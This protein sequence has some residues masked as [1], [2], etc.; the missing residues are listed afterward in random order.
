LLR[1]LWQ[2]TTS[3]ATEVTAGTSGVHSRVCYPHLTLAYADDHAD[4]GLCVPITSSTS[5]HQVI[6]ELGFEQVLEEGLLL[7]VG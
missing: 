5:C 2:V 4:H 1:D 7:G 3:A 6:F